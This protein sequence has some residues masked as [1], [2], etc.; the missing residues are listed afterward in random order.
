M[1]ISFFI[2]EIPPTVQTQVDAHVRS[3]AL[4]FS[5]DMSSEQLALWLRNYPSLS[6]AE[7]E[8]DIIKLR[9]TLPNTVLIIMVLII[10]LLCLDARINGHIFLT[11]DESRLERFSV[12]VGFQFA[13][14][15]I[16]K[17]MVSSLES[18]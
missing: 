18:L 14:M 10:L 13:I 15:N 11:L 4:A 12:S 16:V 6:E 17:D 9:G 8:E 2:I 7:Y 5:E 3:Q 1:I